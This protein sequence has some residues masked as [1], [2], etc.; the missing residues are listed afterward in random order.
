MLRHALLRV[1][2]ITTFF[3]PQVF[4]GGHHGGHHGGGSVSVRGYYRSNGTY[5]APHHRSSPDGNFWNNWSTKGNINPYTGIPGTKVTPPNSGDTSRAYSSSLANWSLP[6]SGRRESNA[7]AYPASGPAHPIDS[8]AGSIASPTEITEATPGNAVAVGERGYEHFQQGSYAQ[9]V[10]HYTRAIEL[11][12]GEHRYF[13]NRGAVYLKSGD[14]DRAIAD[15]HQALGLEPSF[16][17]SYKGLSEAYRQKAMR[18]I[19]VS[20]KPE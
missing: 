4:A 8:A 14:L 3:A 13:H 5:V 9:A 20:A 12:G 11:D 6:T 7:M 16:S 17:E 19:Q 10:A 2:I 1:G 15:F 18:G